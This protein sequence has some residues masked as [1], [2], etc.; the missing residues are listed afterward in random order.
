MSGGYSSGSSYNSE[1]IDNMEMMVI[2]ISFGNKS[3]SLVVHWNDEPEDLAKVN[4][5][6][7]SHLN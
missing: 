7:F 3:D 4:N 6:S 5:L 2:E 1:D